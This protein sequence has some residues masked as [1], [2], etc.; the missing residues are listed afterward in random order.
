MTTFASIT[1]IN[2][3]ACYTCDNTF[4][5]GDLVRRCPDCDELFHNSC[6]GTAGKCPACGAVTAGAPIR[7]FKGGKVFREASGDEVNNG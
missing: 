1:E 4:A 7:V 6:W 2:P 3:A 5:V